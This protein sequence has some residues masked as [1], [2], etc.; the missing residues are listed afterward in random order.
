MAV[1]CSL[2]NKD[3]TVRVATKSDSDST[4]V[5]VAALRSVQL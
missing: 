5:I 1:S 3:T 2:I 4:K